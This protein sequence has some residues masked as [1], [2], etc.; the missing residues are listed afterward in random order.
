MAKIVTMCRQGLVR[1]VSLTDVLKLHFEPVDVIPIGY[2][3]N[4]LETKEMLFT[5]ADFIVVMEAHMAKYVPEAFLSKVLVCEVGP[6]VY[7]RHN[8][9][10]L[11]DKT[12]RWARENQALLGI[13]EHSKKL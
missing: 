8:H 12:W 10:A 13:K 3:A 6:D 4:S 5:W 7:G 11:L 2:F 1:S 9:P